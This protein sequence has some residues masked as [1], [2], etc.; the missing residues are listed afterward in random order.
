MQANG[1]T[2]D[3]INHLLDALEGPPAAG[4]APKGEDAESDGEKGAESTY[5]LQGQ[6]FPPL[7]CLIQ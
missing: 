7:Y 5:E 3:I 1:K 2:A 6:Q 4:G